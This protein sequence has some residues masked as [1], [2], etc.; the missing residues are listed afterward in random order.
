MNFVP[1]PTVAHA[2]EPFRAHAQASPA[3]LILDAA[4]RLLPAL[5]RGQSID[6]SALRE[7]MTAAFGASDAEGAWV[8]KDA[9]DACEAASVLFLR[10]FGPAIRRSAKSPAS[11]LAMLQRVASL[12]P[13]QTRRSQE[14]QALQQFST[15]IDLAFVASIAAGVCE[16]DLVL[17]P[18]AG[19]G[20]L[21]IFAE[22]AGASLALNELAETRA[23]MLTGL[24]PAVALSRH[25]AAQIHDR[26]DEAVRPTIVLMN[27]PFSVAANV[28]GRVRD[29]AIR[30]LT[31]ALARLPDGGR[32]IAI[33]GAALAPSNPAWRSSFVALQSHARVVFTAAVDGRV[34]ARQGTTTDTRLTVIDR[35]KADDPTAF[36]ASHGKAPDCATLLQ[37]VL[38]AVPP[39]AI[40]TPASS[41]LAAPTPIPT[42]HSAAT[43]PG[44]IP[45]RAPSLEPD[46]VELVYEIAT[47]AGEAGA[48]VAEGI[49]EFYALQSVSIPGARPHPT[50]LVQSAAMASV[51]S[52]RP[53]YRPHLP[54]RIVSDALLSDAQLE[55]VNLCRGGPRRPSG[56]LLDG[57]RHL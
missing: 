17:E 15:P 56:G 7:A 54:A 34:Y 25:D 57:R 30:H 6:A 16:R 18:S 31:S 2:A 42:R 45:A 35:I 39:R 36:P 55:S 33:T 40:L 43:P 20:S 23:D 10:K 52:P 46:G 32:L 48:N 51:A 12:L 27:P 37:W 41:R 11:L 26:L 28:E 14:S 53:T 8:W 5:S 24:F 4:A 21:A 22:L 19:T 13:P 44:A 38:S 3:S 47:S 50:R 29:A 49:Y 1:H 9:Y